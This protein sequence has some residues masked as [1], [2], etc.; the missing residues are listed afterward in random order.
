[1]I[2]KKKKKLQKVLN[3]GIKNVVTLRPH[4]RVSRNPGGSQNTL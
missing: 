1:M 2:E 3:P 4:K